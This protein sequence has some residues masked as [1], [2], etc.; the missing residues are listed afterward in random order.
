[1]VHFVSFWSSLAEFIADNG[2]LAVALIVLLRSAAVPIP[3]PADL[4][5]V[6]VGARSREQQ[7]LLWLG[8]VVLAI[9]TT[10]G[11]VLFYAFVRWIGQGDVSH[12][13]RYIGLT[14][15]RLSTAETQ[16][17]ERG[18]RAVFVARIV[19]GLRLAIVAVCG[20]L[21]FQWWKFVAAVALGALI[22]VGLCLMIGYFFGD[23]IVGLVG[24][25]VFPFGV[26]E[27]VLG[28]SILLFWLVR[29]R[30]TTPSL[31]TGEHLNRASRVRVGA[32]AG[33]LA[34]AGSTMLV[35]III[36]LLAPVAAEAVGGIRGVESMVSLS[37][38]LGSL[39]QLVLDSVVVGILWGIVYAI[40][41]GRSAAGW[42]D[43]LRGLAFASLPFMLVMLVQLLVGLQSG[44]SLRAWLVLGIGEAI[45][46]G[47]YGV[48]IGLTYP[49]LRT[50]RL[51]AVADGPSTGRSK[52]AAESAG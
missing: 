27:P 15:D 34:I 32:L 46:W 43:W 4:L 45:R 39:V 13:G 23:V 1:M 42:S 47:T 10:V 51:Q 24:D 17:G 6:V 14:S 29:A 2:L 28:L 3:V 26:L 5:V 37:G 30:S 50:R 20:V 21:R 25:L 12:Y 19:P 41:D 38:G 8:W 36:Y 35:N 9:S 22:Y 33:T 31:A 48:L 7:L 52:M 49:V 44:G 16:L 40:V 11:A 18:T